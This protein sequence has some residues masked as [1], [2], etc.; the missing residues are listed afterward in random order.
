MCLLCVQPDIL[1]YVG[2][3]SYQLSL[4]LLRP[5]HILHLAAHLDA[6]RKTFFYWV[7]SWLLTLLPAFLPGK[8]PRH[9]PSGHFFRGWYLSLH[10]L[11]FEEHL[12]YS[13]HQ[14]IWVQ[15]KQS[16]LLQGY[17]HPTIGPWPEE[18][19]DTFLRPP[20]HCGYT[21]WYHRRVWKPQHD[22]HREG[23][24]AYPLHRWSG[25]P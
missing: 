20:G 6:F 4:I 22:S 18:N 12:S 1:F 9:W 17:L 10:G 3:N 7:G 25:R 13:F 11:I 19:Q 21:E 15:W 16:H 2:R 24:G 23:P 8:R 5:V 14:W